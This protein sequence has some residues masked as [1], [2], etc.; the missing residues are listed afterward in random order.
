MLLQRG[1]ADSPTRATLRLF[2]GNTFTSTRILGSLPQTPP[3]GH[4]TVSGNRLRPASRWRSAIPEWAPSRG[5]GLACAR[6][7]HPR[8]AP[9]WRS[10]RC[11]RHRV[12]WRCGRFASGICRHLCDTRGNR[13][14]VAR[15]H[16]GVT[17]NGKFDLTTVMSPATICKPRRRSSRPCPCFRPIP[18]SFVLG[19]VLPSVNNEPNIS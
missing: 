15:H 11:R 16:L 14:Q 5:L 6:P 17:F 3:G 13:G 19:I 9:G 4:L 7:G 2:P 12:C 1:S 8:Q 10:V 18:A